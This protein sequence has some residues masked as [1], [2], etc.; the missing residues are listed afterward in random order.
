MGSTVRNLGLAHVGDTLN[1]RAR[2]TRNYE[3]KGHKWL[4]IDALV[5]A[6]ETTPVIRAA[7]TAIY[8]PRQLADLA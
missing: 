3:H 1:L 4:E 6:N 5:V 8:R 2:V 7:H